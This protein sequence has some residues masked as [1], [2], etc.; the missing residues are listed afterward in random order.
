MGKQNEI[1][2]GEWARRAVWEGSL[3]IYLVNT[4]LAMGVS[5]FIPM[6]IAPSIFW[7]LPVSMGIMF[8]LAWRARYKYELK[9][10]PWYMKE[11][12]HEQQ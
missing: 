8:G 12:K 9:H 10:P 6:L 3:L 1:S 5:M 2:F 11:V 7:V 4:V